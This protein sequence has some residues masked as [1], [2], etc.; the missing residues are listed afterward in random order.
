MDY[1]NISNISH[2]DKELPQ[3]EVGT[4]FIWRGRPPGDW[5]YQV[6]WVVVE[7]DVLGNCYKICP[8]NIPERLFG[9]SIPYTHRNAV[10]KG[11][12]EFTW[13]ML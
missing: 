2:E 3:F 9:P 7:I 12:P 13:R 1:P 6:V 8:K 10:I 4:E 11:T 5:Q